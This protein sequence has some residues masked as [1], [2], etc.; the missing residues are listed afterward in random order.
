MINMDDQLLQLFRACD[1]DDSGYI[2]IEEVRDICAKFGIDDAE[3]IFEDLD[4]DRDGKVS[5]EDFRAVF[6]DY[7]KGDFSGNTP[8]SPG[9]RR[10]ADSFENIK[11]ELEHEVQV[12]HDAKRRRNRRHEAHDT[13]YVPLPL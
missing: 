12:R 13:K 7:E 5:F 1:T 11:K 3:S 6:E 9:L 4:R 10:N 2:G 8:S